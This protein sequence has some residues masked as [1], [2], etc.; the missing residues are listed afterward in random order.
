MTILPLQALIWQG[1]TFAFR[2]KHFWEQIANALRPFVVSSSFKTDV[3][4]VT[5]KI[6]SI[7]RPA[8]ILLFSL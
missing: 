6:M 1:L 7:L 5:Q 8:W 4:S 3:K 2:M